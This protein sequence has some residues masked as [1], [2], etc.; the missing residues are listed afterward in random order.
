M[1]AGNVY[2]SLLTGFLSNPRNVFTFFALI[3]F[4]SHS[5]ADMID[6]CLPACL[7]TRKQRQREGEAGCPLRYSLHE[8]CLLVIRSSLVLLL[9]EVEVLIGIVVKRGTCAP[10]RVFP[11]TGGKGK[12][13][14]QK[15]DNDVKLLLQRVSYFG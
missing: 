3:A 5:L 1:K 8:K 9:R 2:A 14:R 10:E 4:V 11:F 13:W 7:L 6:C 15:D 12:W